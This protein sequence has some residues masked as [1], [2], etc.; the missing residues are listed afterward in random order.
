MD[1]PIRFDEWMQQALYGSGGF[2]TAGGQA[3]RRGDFLT[4]PEVGPLFGAVLARAVDAEWERQER[5]GRFVL[6]DVG[7]GPGTLARA[8][9]A[10]APAVAA[11]GALEY[12][13]VETSEVQRMAQPAAVTSVAELPA[14]P[15][16]GFVVANE[17]LDNLAFRLAVWDDAWREAWVVERDGRAE[18]VLAP[19]DVV[20]RCLPSGGVPHGARAPVQERAG[21]WILDARSCLS[22]G[23]VVVFDYCSATTAGLAL[24]PWRQWLR[25]YR[26]HQRGGHYLAA[27]GSQD[28]TAEV[29]VDQL[30][31]V[32][33]EPDAVRTQ[34][35]YLAYWGIDEL[36]AEGRRWWEAKAHAPDLEAIRGRSR[37]REAE[38]LTDANGLGGFTVL[39]WTV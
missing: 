12:V 38:A 30:A 6:V 1:V 2:Y 39:E 19:F 20:P 37:V 23:R 18:E 13:C 34:A 31:A 32:A 4:A 9:L 8:V 21:Q 28:I 11:A 26:G 22:A 29:C 14:G 27:P 24:R 25:T 5:P 36:V 10:A 33:G 7:A 35:Q 17:L 16:A 3:G 15:F